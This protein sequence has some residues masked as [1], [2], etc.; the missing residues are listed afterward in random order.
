M[1]EA[2]DRLGW[3]GRDR[4]DLFRCVGFHV[5]F[6]ASEAGGD[7]LPPLV[8][9]PSKATAPKSGSSNGRA[10]SPEIHINGPVAASR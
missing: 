10:C 4:L 1:G 7:T 5:F 2:T 6:E 9:R 3:N 8:N